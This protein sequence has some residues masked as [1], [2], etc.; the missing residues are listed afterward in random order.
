MIRLFCFFSDKFVILNPLVTTT[1]SGNLEVFFMKKFGLLILT[2]GLSCFAFANEDDSK[3]DDS[4]EVAQVDNN[5]GC[6][7]DKTETETQ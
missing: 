6:E 3:T 1:K 2:L 4:N 5:C 7:T